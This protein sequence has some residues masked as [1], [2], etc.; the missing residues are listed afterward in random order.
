LR[1]AAWRNRAPGTSATSTAWCSRGGIRKDG[2][3]DPWFPLFL[4]RRLLAGGLTLGLRCGFFAHHRGGR[5]CPGALAL[6]ERDLDVRHAPLI[7]I[8][9]AHRGWADALH[10]RTFIGDRA[11]DVEVVDIDIQTPFIADVGGVLDRR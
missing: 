7:A 1:G 4:L 11:R 2:L 6:G 9:A 3:F 10:A 8:G 5:L